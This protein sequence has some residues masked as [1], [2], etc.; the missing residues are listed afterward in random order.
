[1]AIECT[2][3]QA[4]FLGALQEREIE[5]LGS[6]VS[7]PVDVRIIAATNRDLQKAI[8]EGILRE[9]PPLRAHMD[10]V[11]ILAMHFLWRYAAR[12]GTTKTGIT[13]AARPPSLA[14]AGRGTCASSKTPSSGRWCSARARRSG[15]RTSRPAST[16][17]T[18]ISRRS[19]RPT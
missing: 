18:A 5:R 1:M 12:E 4:K 13:D 17:R 8:A 11:P 19:S 2:S 10:D 6:S 14:S 9:V 3:L 15:S 16:S 7:F